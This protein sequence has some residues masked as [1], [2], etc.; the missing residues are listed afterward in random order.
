MAK[1]PRSLVVGTAGHIDHGKTALVRALTGVDTDRLPEEKRRGITIDLGFA[2]WPLGG[3]LEASVVDV[4]GHEAFVRTMVAGAGG[5]DL[6]ILVIAADE[7]V[8]PQTREHLHIAALLGVRAAVVALTKVDRLAG[9]REALELAEDEVREVLAGTPLA[10]APLLPCS[11]HT[12]E[13]L[14]ALR[15]AVRRLAAQLP[16]RPLRDR[17]IV[18][19]DRAFV[20]KGHGTVATGT[21][22]AGRIQPDR[23]DRLDLV[24]VGADRPALDARVRGLQVRGRPAEEAAAGARVA[25]NLGGLA[26]DDVRRGDVLTRGRRVARVEVVH[27]WIERLPHDRAD[28]SAGAALAVCAG[29]AHAEARLAALADPAGAPADDLPPGTSGYARLILDPPIPA[30]RGQRLI[31][32]RLHGTRDPEGDTVAG[33]VVLDPAPSAGRGQRPRWI[34][35][36]PA[37]AADDPAR[38]VAAL[39]ADAGAR[40]LDLEGAELR[41]GLADPRPVLEALVEESRATP[42]AGDRWVDAAVVE[43]LAAAAA[44]HVERHHAQAPLQ[45]GLPRRAVEAALPERPAADV[46]AA[47]VGR[48]C[49]GGELV[50]VDDQGALARPQHVRQTGAYPPELAAL[51]GLYRR[52]GAAPPTLK[53]V[54]AATGM[55]PRQVLDAVA[56]LQRAGALIKIT[57]ELSLAVESHDALLERIRAHL[58]ERGE[59]DVQALKGL[60]D[61]SRKFVVPLLEHLDRLQVTRRVGDRR[62]PGPRA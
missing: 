28:W 43:R 2:P 46:A 49:A 9:D 13:G 12:G 57:P 15:A 50:R 60:T 14:D 8:M 23:E 18:A 24:R 54:E 17:P 33:G 42:L 29:T 27:A 41:A 4:P 25:V 39:L 52:G 30:W 1:A 58:R 35:L 61:L 44:A 40:G 19:I 7:G 37:L 53:E 10:G 36:A 38:R 3:G 59:L 48:A 51:L 55:T 32:R 16:P 34:A 47:A 22:L 45:P 26:V 31:L 6:L 62:L 21:L 56:V 11:A 5:V 20:I